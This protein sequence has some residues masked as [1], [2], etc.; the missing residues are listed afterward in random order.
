MAKTAAP[1]ICRIKQLPLK[2]IKIIQFDA[3]KSRHNIYVPS[4]F[5]YR[6]FLISFCYDIFLVH[7]QECS[8]L[9][10]RRGYAFENIPM[11][12]T[13]MY[14]YTPRKV[15][16]P[17]I[18]WKKKSGMSVWAASNLYLTIVPAIH[19]YIYIHPALPRPYLRHISY[20]VYVADY[21]RFCS[22]KSTKL[23]Q[24][25]LWDFFRSLTDVGLIWF[26]RTG[27]LA[28]D[29]VPTDTVQNNARTCRVLP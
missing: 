13:S 20:S 7:V 3:C 24:T 25:L 5:K 6:S 16:L 17:E 9:R 15:M 10:C 1:A 27:K 4:N 23:N 29:V 22:R 11:H 19:A 12:C 21:R 28:E 2:R 18:T 26:I 14:N 8:L